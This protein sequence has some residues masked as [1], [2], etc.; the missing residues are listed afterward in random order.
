MLGKSLKIFAARALDVG[1][2][3]V[4]TEHANANASYFPLF[5]THSVVC[6]K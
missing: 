1:I 4:L 3:L 5:T 6:G 2:K